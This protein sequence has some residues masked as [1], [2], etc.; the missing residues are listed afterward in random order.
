MS[1]SAWILAGF[2]LGLLHAAHCAGMC[3]VFALRATTRP[4][5]FLMFGLGKCFSYVFLG[6]LA[7]ALGASVGAQMDEVRH[8]LALLV[9]LSLLLAAAGRL[10]WRPLVRGGALLGRAWRTVFGDL[11]GRALPGGSFTL[12]VLTGLL[13][14]GVVIVAALQSAAF[15]DTARAAGFMVAFGAG[16][17]PVL[18]GTV[19]AAH[20]LRERLGSRLWTALSA[21][22][23]L[24]A[25]LITLWRAAAPLLRPDAAC[26]LCP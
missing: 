20:R 6:T 21:S 14:C 11:L 5:G 3:G 26:G 22:L 24:A 15:G 7:G 16:T 18:L 17:L 19:L 13:P 9:G 23:L 10:G 4:G 8:V 25:A 12:G 2:G 1:A